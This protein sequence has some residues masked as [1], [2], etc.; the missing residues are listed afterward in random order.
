MAK[1]IKLP[2]GNYRV[3]LNITDPITKKILRP[4]FT[5]PTKEEALVMANEYLI[6]VR[7]NGVH[8]KDGITLKEAIDNHINT[9]AFSRSPSTIEGYRQIARNRFKSLMAMPISKITNAML[10]KTINDESKL[11]TR[12]GEPISPKTI[13]TSFALITSVIK[14][15]NP[16]LIID[17]VLPKTIK[18]IKSLPSAEEVISAIKGTD[19]ELPCMLSIWLSLSLSE[20]LGLRHNS[21]KGRY[22]Y[23]EQSRILINGKMIVKNYMKTDTRTRVLEIPSYIYSLI[24]AQPKTEYLVNM[25]GNQIYKRLQ[26]YLKANNLQPLRF[27][28]L[29]H[30]NASVMAML[31]IPDKYAQERGGWSTDSIMKSVYQHTFDAQRQIVDHQIDTYF[32]SI[33]AETDTENGHD[34]KDS[35]I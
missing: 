22:L 6:D 16:R 29:R 12:N 28:E 33:L 14:K 25:S 8:R 2:S 9:I 5:A 27:H 30:L 24:Q 20:I 23:I 18:K 13:N 32:E 21:I 1:A 15:H 35:L 10:Q 3:R 17:V 19:I 11:T 7:I 26:K 31:H 34:I 4:S